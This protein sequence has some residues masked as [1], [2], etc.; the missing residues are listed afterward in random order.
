MNVNQKDASILDNR[1]ISQYFLDPETQEPA[2]INSQETMHKIPFQHKIP[3]DF[4]LKKNK[5]D[6]WQVSLKMEKP[7]LEKFYD[8]LTPEERQKADR[9]R[10]IQVKERYVASRG[11]LRWILGHYLE[12]N[13]CQLEFQYGKHG[14]PGLTEKCNPKGITFNMSHSYDR[15]LYGVALKRALGVDIEKIRED[16]SFLKISK[17]FFTGI[18]HDAL[19]LLTPEM[20]K[21][22]FFNCWTRK[23]AYIKAKGS[24]IASEISR[25]SVSLVPGQPAVML[26]HQTDPL[27]VF[28]WS[29]SSLDAGGDYKA[30]LVMEGKDIPHTEITKNE[31]LRFEMPV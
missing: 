19:T 17:R 28:R 18:E 3:A 22:G 8:F 16:M 7:C 30:A 24:A 4:S 2:S 21:H 20:R 1:I 23:E 29:F 15:A 13:P 12:K 27:E 5:V 11:V 10:F 14:K 25:F 9:L 6:I 26:A 31:V